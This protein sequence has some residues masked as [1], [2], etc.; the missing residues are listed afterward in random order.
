MLYNLQAFLFV[1]PDVFVLFDKLTRFI[2]AR[3]KNRGE[4]GASWK[5]FPIFLVCF[6]HKAL[7]GFESFQSR[8]FLWGVGFQ[9]TTSILRI[10]ESN[11]NTHIL[12]STH[13]VYTINLQSKTDD[14]FSKPLEHAPYISSFS[15]VFKRNLIPSSSSTSQL[16]KVF[17]NINFI[18]KREREEESFLCDFLLLDVFQVQTLWRTEIKGR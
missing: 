13:R 8:E 14:D 5:S 3:Q 10:G 18:K 2:L 11:N 16:W 7:S 1:S 17:Q 4:T 9:I 12:K 6:M 15:K